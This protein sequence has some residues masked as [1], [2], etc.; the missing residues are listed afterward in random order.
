M[1]HVRV[2]EQNGVN[3]RQVADEY[4]GAALAAQDNQARGED[5]INEKA[6]AA[7]L[8]QERGMTDEGDGGFVR[9]YRRG[10]LGDSGEGRSVAF[11]YQAPEL[12][13]FRDPEGRVASHSIDWMRGAGKG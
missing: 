3:A 12:F 2:G 4:T 10:D 5:G 9:G 7:G 13:E 11:A 1:V 8:E 6:V